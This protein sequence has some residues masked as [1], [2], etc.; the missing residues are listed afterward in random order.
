MHFPTDLLK[1][2]DISVVNLANIIHIGCNFR[3]NLG[4]FAANHEGEL[5]GV[6]PKTSFIEGIG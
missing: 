1:I 2:A 6:T 3:L 5:N 4:D